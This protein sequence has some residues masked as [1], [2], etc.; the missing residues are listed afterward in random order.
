MI[1]TNSFISTSIEFLSDMS[2]FFRTSMIRRTSDLN[3][4]VANSG[5]MMVLP[6]KAMLHLI[7]NIDHSESSTDTFDPAKYPFINSRNNLKYL[8]NFVDFSAVSKADLAKFSHRIYRPKLAENLKNY[9]MAHRKIMIPAQKLDTIID[10]KNCIVIEN[11]NPLYRIISTTQRPISQYDRYRAFLTT[12]LKNTLNYNRQHILVIP[13]PDTFTYIR[14]NLMAIIQ[15]GI[16]SS[17]KLL[18]TSH[19]YFFIIDLVALL[20]DNNSKMSTF[21]VIDR[22]ALSNLNVMLSNGDKSIIVNIGKLATLAKSKTYIFS[23]ID[24]ISRISGVDVPVTILP[25]ADADPDVEAD[26]S[27]HDDKAAAAPQA[28]TLGNN[29]VANNTVITKAI[30]EQIV[31]D[32]LYSNDARI[33]TQ[34]PNKSD[35]DH[36]IILPEKIPSKIEV[37]KR[38]VE[39]PDINQDLSGMSQKQKD[40]IEILQSKYKTIPV[41]T[42]FGTKSIEE[43]LNEPIDI[44]IKPIHLPIENSEGIEPS[45]MATTTHSFDHHYRTKLLRK[46]ILANIISFK[47]NGL[48]L[49]DYVEKNNYNSFTRIKHVKA[50]FHDIRGKRHTV[51]FKLPIPDDEGYYLVNGVR[52]CMS[53]QLVNIPICKISPTRVSLISN[54]NKTLV[55]KVE[56]TRHSLPEYLASKSGDHDIKLVPKHN[57]YIGLKLPYDYK[58]LGASYAKLITLTHVFFFEYEDRY[59]FFNT[60]VKMRGLTFESLE[61]RYGVMI[62]R[63]IKKPTEIIFMDQKNICTIVN[64]ETGNAIDGKLSIVDFFGNFRV[65]TEWCNLKILDKNLPIIFILA[66][67]Y[68]LTNVLTNMQIKYRFVAK[69]EKEVT[70][71]KNT[72]IAIHFTDGDIVFDRYPLYHSYIL[73]GFTQFP[74]LNR[75][76]LS[77]FDGKDVY[78]Q[79]L[80]DKG[81]STNYL[82]GIDSYFSFFIDPITKEVLHEMGEPTNTRDLLLRAVDMLVDSVDKVPSAISNFRVRSA[83]KLP[84]MIYNEISRQYANYINSNFKDVSFSINTEAIFQRLIQDET[85]TLREDLN[86]VHAIKET[87]RVTY[88]GFGGRSSEAFVARDRKYPK[89]AIGILG[90]TTTDSGSVGMVSYL[91]GDPKIKNLRGMFHT[92]A[93]DLNSTNVLS[94]TTLLMPGSTHDDPKRLIN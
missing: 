87:N 67:R 55:D 22:R 66:Y 9:G 31:E 33:I 49:T 6:K 42:P 5:P 44:N 94:E 80:S 56:S 39:I 79:L 86:P 83:E 41:S 27:E 62:G 14:S 72:E 81:M 1:M 65:P 64:V 88:A 40:R 76:A 21:N 82:K 71:R 53:K 61:T 69:R 54:Y 74:T 17:Q 20:L 30:P 26:G 84:A 19:F 43:V 38:I 8:H 75:Y 51:N 52:L 18:S 90:E 85:M 15:P 68:G 29:L 34:E 7:D 73:A 77:D 13:V 89:D 92:D 10:N 28:A 93:K 25:D 58:S 36:Q 4:R 59:A 45:M 16:I 12:V 46:D 11:Y 70:P 37:V 23:F 57:I 2:I 91:T 47:D 50:T 48:F 3:T 78:Y 24:N 32:N 35:E 60:T 63:S